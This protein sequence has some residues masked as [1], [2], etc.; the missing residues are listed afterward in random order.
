MPTPSVVIFDVD[1][2][3]VDSVDL[4]AMAWKDAFEEFGYSVDFAQARSQIGK[5]GD[6]LLPV[7]LTR[8]E[9]SR[10]GRQLEKRR[11]EIFKERYFSRVKSFEGVRPLFDR[12]LADG[13]IIALGS[14]ANADELDHYKKVAKIGDLEIAASAADNVEHSKPHPDIFQSTLERT[15]AQAEHA[16]VVGDT[17]YD[18]QAAR[19]AGIRAI[20]MLSGGWTENELRQAGCIAIYAGPSD[21][22]AGYSKSP[23]AV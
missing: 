16:I 21:L 15:G 3:L 11:S 18:A 8:T 4:H 2:T 12:L 6:Q 19:R 9:C 13:K 17:P 14:S 22:L 20:G 1:G 7:F 23:L 5:G 10:I